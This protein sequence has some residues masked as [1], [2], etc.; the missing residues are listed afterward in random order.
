MQRVLDEVT[1]AFALLPVLS[2]MQWSHGGPGGGRGRPSPPFPDNTAAATAKLDMPLYIGDITKAN[3][4][5]Q[6]SCVSCD[7]PCMIGMHACVAV[8]M[9]CACAWPHGCVERWRAMP[10]PVLDFLFYFFIVS[11]LGLSR[12]ELSL[13]PENVNG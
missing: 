5:L 8:K 4:I 1:A 2:L 9:P 13:R 10:Q 11:V 12:L 7:L 6:L 3:G